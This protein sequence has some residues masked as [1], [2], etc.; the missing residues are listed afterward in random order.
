[1]CLLWYYFYFAFI[2]TVYHSLWSVVLVINKSV[3]NEGFRREMNSGGGGGAQPH[4]DPDRDHLWLATVI[5]HI[6]ELSSFVGRQLNNSARL[7]TLWTYRFNKSAAHTW[8]FARCYVHVHHGQLQYQHQ[9]LQSKFTPLDKCHSSFIQIFKSFCYLNVDDFILI[10]NIDSYKPLLSEPW[11]S[12][13][14]SERHDHEC[15]RDAYSEV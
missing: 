15:L 14:S 10:P 2:L 1:M 3:V 4:M 13:D 9:P 5:D 12:V 11:R 7:K 6:V 8:W